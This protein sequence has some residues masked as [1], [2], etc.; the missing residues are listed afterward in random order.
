MRSPLGDFCV[1]DGSDGSS[2]VVT[3]FN[4]LLHSYLH[5]SFPCI[6]LLL[7]FHYFAISTCL[8]FFSATMS[9]LFPAFFTRCR[10]FLM[11]S[12]SPFLAS[13]SYLGRVRV[14]PVFSRIK[15]LMTLTSA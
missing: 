1:S 14:L 7:F 11:H 2:V 4:D 15:S 5:V 8:A 12:S 10:S 6:H 3:S 13:S 9:E